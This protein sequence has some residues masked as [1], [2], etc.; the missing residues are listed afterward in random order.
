MRGEGRPE[1]GGYRN[2]DGRDHG[3]T[4]SHSEGETAQTAF[5]TQT[6]NS[7]KME[8]EIEGCTP[9]DAARTFLVVNI[10]FDVLQRF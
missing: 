8:P 9:T 5:F 4:T 2:A 6:V 7:A 10:K 1:R 3:Q